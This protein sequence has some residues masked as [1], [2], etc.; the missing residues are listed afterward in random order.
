M[1]RFDFVCQNAYRKGQLLR[2]PISVGRYHSTRV[3]EGRTKTWIFLATMMKA[4]AVAWVG[5]RE[6]M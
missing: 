2:A 5:E 4:Y 3:D 6:P 1:M